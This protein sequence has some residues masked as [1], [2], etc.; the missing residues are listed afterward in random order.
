MWLVILLSI[1]FII[2]VFLVWLFY[3][4]DTHIVRVKKGQIMEFKST[5]NL[6]GL[7]IVTFTQ[8]DKKFHFLFDTGSNVNYINK[9]SDI[10]FKSTGRK[11]SYIG[12]EGVEQSTSEAF[13]ELMHND[14]V[15]TCQ[16]H[17]ADLNQAFGQLKQEYGVSLSGIIGTSFMEKYKYVVD[18]VEYVVYQRK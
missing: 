15:F 14:M 7:P 18:F 3:T 16:V 17:I 12:A 11:S 8:G 1:S 13:V 9:G 6:T 5:M 4:K 10:M 2:C